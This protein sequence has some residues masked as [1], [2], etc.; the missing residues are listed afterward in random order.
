MQKDIHV[1]PWLSHNSFSKVTV[2]WGRKLEREVNTPSQLYGRKLNMQTN[3]KWVCS[4]VRSGPMI[5]CNYAKRCSHNYKTLFFVGNAGKS[6]KRNVILKMSRI[7]SRTSLVLLLHVY[8]HYWNML[9]H[10]LLSLILSEKITRVH[11]YTYKL[12][13]KVSPHDGNDVST[14]TKVLSPKL[15]NSFRWWWDVTLGTFWNI[16]F[17]DSPA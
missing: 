10:S 14:N 17:C 6:S 13:C 5:V 15:L 4:C 7:F 8:A 16:N 12:L 3:D 11:D 1:L 9:L 2:K